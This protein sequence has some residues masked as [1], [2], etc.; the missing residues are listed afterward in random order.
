MFQTSRF[1]EPLQDGHVV[2]ELRGDSPFV[3]AQ[4]QPVPE[5]NLTRRDTPPISVLAPALL[6]E[7][8]HFTAR[9]H[10]LVTADNRAVRNDAPADHG[11]SL[12]TVLN[13]VRAI[14][15]KL[16]YA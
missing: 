16:N 5:L 6:N 9:G 4:L 8:P 14:T 10:E 12:A 13:S 11:R 2:A 15:P 1:G 7:R 3:R